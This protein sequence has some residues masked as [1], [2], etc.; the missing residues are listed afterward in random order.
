MRCLN[1]SAGENP[2]IAMTME[3]ELNVYVDLNRAPVHIGRLWIRD[4]QGKETATFQ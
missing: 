1:A 2:S 3:R 4:K